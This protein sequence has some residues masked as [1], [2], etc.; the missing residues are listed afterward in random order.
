MRGSG[1][2]ALGVADRVAD[3]DRVDAGDHRDAR[4]RRASSSSTR[5]RPRVPNSLVTRKRSAAPALGHAHHGRAAHEPPARDAPDHE[6]ADEVVV[7]ERHRLELE[8]PLE[9]DRGRR[10]LLEDRL[11]QRPQVAAR[12][13]RVER[14]RC[15][16][17]PRRRRPGSR[18]GGRRRRARRAGRTPR[19]PPRPRAARA[20]RPC[21][22]PAI[23]RS[24]CA[25]A[26]PST[27]R[28]CGITPSTASTSSS[29]ASTMPS[30]RSTSPPK[31]AWPG[32]ST[33]WM[34]T[35]SNSMEVSL[36]WI[37]MPRSRS[38]SSLSITRSTTAWLAR[39]RAGLAQQ[40]IDQRRLAV[41]DVRDDRE[42]AEV[43]AGLGG[44]HGRPDPS[45]RPGAGQRARPAG[46]ASGLPSSCARPRPMDDGGPE[47]VRMQVL[48]CHDGELTDVCGM[49]RELRCTFV[50][51]VGA[52]PLADLARAWDLVVASPIRALR[53]GSAVGRPETRSIVVAEPGT[54]TAGRRLHQLGVEWI[55]RRPV[56][57]AALRLLIQH[58][59]YRGPERRRAQRVSIGLPIRY[60]SRWLPR[61]ARAAG[62]VAARSQ[63]DRLP[64]GVAGNAHLAPAG[65]P[66]RPDHLA[67]R[68]GALPARRGERG[69]ARRRL[70]S[71]SARSDPGP[72]PR[73]GPLRP[74]AR[75]V[76]RFGSPRPRRRPARPRRRGPGPPPS[77]MRSA[78]RRRGACSPGA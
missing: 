21:S 39:K 54:R 52:A 3:L 20:G 68:G 14:R 61:R 15:P 37:V 26:L 28:V 46:S 66:G 51:R 70:R 36:A 77:R 38:R 49:L 25:S 27:K 73:D 17:S 50:E 58:A 18:A 44:V 72:A 33:S 45:S 16:P 2:G 19:R 41:V 4:P 62:D 9:V 48:V 53:L 78:A 42:V 59:L 5:S 47:P 40:C 34:R 29:T 31:S 67:R 71:P 6:A 32:V 30:T 35:P 60:R 23:G 22:P 65:G 43:F 8:R 13:R 56:H 76:Q 75:R 10:R 1:S 24:P 74:G 69:G 55:V 63:P 12:R 7:A 57:P 11:E 64:A